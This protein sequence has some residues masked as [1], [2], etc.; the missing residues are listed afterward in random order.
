MQVNGLFKSCMST[1][2]DK[3][4][5]KARNAL[6]GEKDKL[7]SS[8]YR[9]L[10]KRYPQSVTVLIEGARALTRAGNVTA[11]RTALEQ[12]RQLE[13]ELL[14]IQLHVASGL[15]KLGDYAQAHRLLAELWSK[16]KQPEVGIALVEVCERIGNIDEA[17]T[18]INTLP[19][20]HPRV[21][22]LKGVLLRRNRN[23]SDAHDTL[24]SLTDFTQLDNNTRLRA[25]LL[26]AQCLEKL[27][28]YKAAW[29]TMSEAH[30]QSAPDASIRKKLD[31]TYQTHI[32]RARHS[33]SQTTEQ[34]V[35]TPQENSPMLVSGHPRSGTSVIATH[36]ADEHSCIHLDEIGAFARSLDH[37]R[38][39]GKSPQRV[40][41]FGRKKFQDFYREQMIAFV[42]TAEDSEN[43]LDKNPGLERHANLWLSAFPDSQIKLIR[44]HPL[45]CLIS[46]LFTYLPLNPFSLQFTTTE[47]TAGSIVTSL[48]FQQK[49]LEHA[50]DSVEIIHYEQFLNDN[51]GKQVAPQ[52][53][54]HSPNYGAAQ[55]KVHAEGMN[56][57]QHYLDFIPETIAEQLS[58]LS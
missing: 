25:S 20:S 31:Q 54:M 16:S 56:R 52:E 4:L 9:Q 46:C 55:E 43:W 45:D 33:W 35:S 50:P 15:F 51:L 23:Y 58:D 17:L 53:S 11:A 24:T 28:D 34:H 18:I 5:Q 40:E 41:S 22:L 30:L 49:L 48:E 10:I 21:L 37:A 26:M 2:F 19:E 38:L 44:R 47:R 1:S 36:L 13:P 27:G 32:E 6:L 8:L 12:A 3:A 57:Y 14:E 29:S 42:P 39:S 7:A